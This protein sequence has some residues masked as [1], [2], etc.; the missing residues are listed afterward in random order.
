MIANGTGMKVAKRGMIG[1]DFSGG[2]PYAPLVPLEE[3]IGAFS[4][5]LDEHLAKGGFGGVGELLL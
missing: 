2:D 5:Y 1:P 4:P 3:T